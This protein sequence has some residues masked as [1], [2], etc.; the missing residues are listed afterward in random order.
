MLS[1]SVHVTNTEKIKQNCLATIW[2][3]AMGIQPCKQF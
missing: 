3:T 2:I 1:T